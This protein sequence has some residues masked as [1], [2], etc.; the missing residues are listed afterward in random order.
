[1]TAIKLSAFGGEIPA[2]DSRLLPEGQSTYA[3]NCYLLGGNLIG[4]RQPELL[5]TLNNSAAKFVYRIVND[6]TNNTKIT[7][8]DSVLA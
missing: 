3:L 6:N 1:M 4:W 8:D 2:W 7:A 5:H